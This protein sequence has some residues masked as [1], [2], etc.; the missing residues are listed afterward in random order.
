M[1][2]IEH[3]N[4]KSRLYNMFLK[5]EMARSHVRQVAITNA[6]GGRRSVQ[7]PSAPSWR[8]P[9]AF[10]VAN[11]AI[12]HSAAMVCAVNIGEKIFRDAR[13]SLIADGENSMLA[14]MAASRL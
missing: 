5:V 1:P 10:D 8:A 14:I 4:V 9:A 6:A 2:L 13:A 11:D 12:R 3:Q 7:L